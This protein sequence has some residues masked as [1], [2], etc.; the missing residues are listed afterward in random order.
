ML[1]RK[2][3]LCITKKK[4]IFFKTTNIYL[5]LAV[6][7]LRCSVGFSLIA[8][9]GACPLV[10]VHRLLI[11]VASLVQHGLLGAGFSNCG[12]WALEHRL[13]SC[14]A[15]AQLLSGMWD[16]PGP[17]IEADSLL[18]SHQGSLTFSNSNETSVFKPYCSLVIEY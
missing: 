4:T 18:L 2:L 1:E 14:G 17:G 15:W 6:L 16:L 11:A 10:A 8:G 12:S 7:G 3:S 13:N 5:F 9:R